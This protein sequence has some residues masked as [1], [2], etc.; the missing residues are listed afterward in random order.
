MKALAL[1]TGAAGLRHPD[2]S[3]PRHLVMRKDDNS[4]MDGNDVFSCLPEGY[5]LDDK[6]EELLGNKTRRARARAH[7]FAPVD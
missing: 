6:A 2:E 3:L 4:V 7:S 1:M 5:L